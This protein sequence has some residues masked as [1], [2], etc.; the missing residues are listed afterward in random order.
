MSFSKFFQHVGQSR[1][2]RV[3]TFD[4]QILVRCIIEEKI[5]IRFQPILGVVV[6][7]EYGEKRSGSM[8]REISVS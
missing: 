1:N 7:D 5:Q 6:A 4:G 3:D 8:I 2:K